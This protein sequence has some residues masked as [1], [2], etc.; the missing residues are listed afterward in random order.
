MPLTTKARHSVAAIVG[1]VPQ[2]D[3]RR[4]ARAGRRSVPAARV[5]RREHQPDLCTSAN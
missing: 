1:K 2:S 3:M 5:C 4:P